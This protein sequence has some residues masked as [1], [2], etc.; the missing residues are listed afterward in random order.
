MGV[1]GPIVEPASRFLEIG[2]GD[3]LQGC[4]VRAEFVRD[5]G[6]RTSVALHR[7]LDELQ[8]RGLVA[9]GVHEGFQPLSLVI[10]GGPQVAQL[11]VE[12][13]VDLVEMPTPMVSARMCSTRFLRISPANIG[14]NRFHQSRTV[15]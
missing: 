4:G 13:H 9:G 8:R 6:S 14:P 12:S 7:L 5:D 10:D 3:L 15:S 1:F 11:A 2:G